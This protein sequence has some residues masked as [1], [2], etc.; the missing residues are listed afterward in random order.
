MTIR[1]F[2]DMRDLPQWTQSPFV[3]LPFTGCCIAI[4]L[5]IGISD[6][7]AAFAGGLTAALAAVVAV[8]LGGAIQRGNDRARERRAHAASMQKTVR[9]IILSLEIFEALL[10]ALGTQLR[11]ELQDLSPVLRTTRS[12]L[13]K[14]IHTAAPELNKRLS[15]EI[16]GM[17][18]FIARSITS[19]AV[20]R[21]I[22]RRT[23]DAP[24][25][26]IGR[27]EA[28]EILD[29]SYA[30][31]KAMQTALKAL[32]EYQQDLEAAAQT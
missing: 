6:R 23:V 17:N 9:E 32:R 21:E 15:D 13:A 18:D 14:S 28:S 19:Y 3:V 12:A 16:F 22:L 7:A 30:C 10:S 26:S 5:L 25:E 1:S 24:L 20:K 29:K 11:K 31:L 2:L 8:V 4:P 27:V